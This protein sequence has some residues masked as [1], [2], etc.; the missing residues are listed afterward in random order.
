MID[1]I[2]PLDELVRWGSPLHGL[3][4]DGQTKIR[5]GEVEHNFLYDTV[6]P[7]EITAR[8][9][10]LLSTTGVSGWGVNGVR[11]YVHLLQVPGTPP[12]DMSPEEIGAEQVQGRNWLDHAL[13]AGPRQ[14]L[15]SY[16][17]N[18]WVHI[19][20]LGQRWYVKAPGLHMASLMPSDPLELALEVRPFGYLDQPPAD[21]VLLNAE[22]LDIGQVPVDPDLNLP[23]SQGL[24]VLIHSISPDGR[25]VILAVT[26]AYPATPS[27]QSPYFWLPVGWLCITLEGSGPEFDVQVEVLYTRDQ[28]MGTK[29]DTQSTVLGRVPHLLELDYSITG[30]APNLRQHLVP[31]GGI[32]YLDASLPTEAG[33]QQRYLAH[34]GRVCNLAFSNTGALV[35]TTA[36]SEMLIELEVGEAVLTSYSGE[37][38]ADPGNNQATGGEISF[39]SRRTSSDSTLCSITVRQDGDV[40]ERAEWS[41][42]VETV[43]ERSQVADRFNTLTQAEWSPPSFVAQ[44][45]VSAGALAGTQTQT[46][47]INGVQRWSWSSAIS[48]YLPQLVPSRNVPTHHP[49]WKVGFLVEVLPAAGRPDRWLFY[50]MAMAGNHVNSFSFRRYPASVSNPEASTAAPTFNIVHRFIATDGGWE[51]SD[52]AGISNTRRQP[53]HPAYNPATGEV[54]YL[55]S[56][57]ISGFYI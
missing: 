24:R 12:L 3:V 47:T 19:D 41:R 36:D 28:T 48:N 55:A 10:S 54:F 15:F 1:I 18:G 45:G 51:S 52:W 32:E 40:V 7:I 46:L 43:G 42:L 6:L 11:S 26:V 16:A 57:P 35:T 53:V 9:E 37:L 39:T 27:D 21:P 56:Q 33:S 17:L 2:D 5:M 31:S 29:T 34:M 30:T 14:G 8:W 22:L 25:Q 50:R 38:Y 23:P 13:I 49:P 20:E 4:L 44:V